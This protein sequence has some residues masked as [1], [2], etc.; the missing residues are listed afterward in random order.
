VI[1]Q[2]RAGWPD[3]EILLALAKILMAFWAPDAA[4]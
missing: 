1:H 2:L 4:R 3:V